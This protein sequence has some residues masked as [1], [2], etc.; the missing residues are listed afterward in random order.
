MDHAAGGV[1]DNTDAVLSLAVLSLVV[2]SLVVM[3]LVV[4]SLNN[5]TI[6]VF[7]PVVTI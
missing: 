7:Q 2:L 5:T 3:S 1:Q 6:S 4:M